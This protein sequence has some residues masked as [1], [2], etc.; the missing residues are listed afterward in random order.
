MTARAG[1]ATG[2]VVLRAESAFAA[3]VVVVVVV[4]VVVARARNLGR[5]RSVLDLRRPSRRDHLHCVRR[6]P[7]A[8]TARLVVRRVSRQNPTGQGE[9]LPDWRYHAFLTTP[10]CPPSMRI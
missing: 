4:V 8:V 1:G 6:H 9:L 10:P 5:E 7:P 2:L 3:A